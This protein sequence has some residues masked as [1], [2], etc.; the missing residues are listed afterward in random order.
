METLFAK[1]R[2]LIGLPI[3]IVINNSVS[4]RGSV[5]EIKPDH[6]YFKNTNGLNQYV[7]LTGIKE[8]VKDSKENKLMDNLFSEEPINTKENFGDLLKS[9]NGQWLMVA[10]TN[11]TDLTGVLCDVL[12]DIAV[13]ID[14]EKLVFVPISHIEY[15]Q[16][17]LVNEERESKKEES[18]EASSKDESKNQSANPSNNESKDVKEEQAEEQLNETQKEVEEV[19]EEEEAEE[20]IEDVEEPL[21]FKEL[22]EKLNDPKEYAEAPVEDLLSDQSPLKESL[23]SPPLTPNKMVHVVKQTVGSSERLSKPFTSLFDDLLS[24]FSQRQRN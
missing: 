2:S 17:Q 21:G 3:S 15:V 23:L 16:D 13:F 8:I 14:K 11:M 4:L 18:N 22:T 5:L 10:R 20:E 1:L 9:F 12:E 7:Q 24:A 19:E 6:L